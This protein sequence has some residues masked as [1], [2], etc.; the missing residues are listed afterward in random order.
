MTLTQIPSPTGGEKNIDSKTI[1]LD[2]E[3]ENPSINHDDRAQDGELLPGVAHMKAINESLT[4]R[5]RCCLIFS[6]FLVCYA[7]NLNN[8]TLGTYQGYA[9]SSWDQHSL[10]STINVIR[11]VIS[12]AVMPLTAKVS[13]LVGRVECF[14]IA[15]AFYVVGTVVQASAQNIET[16]AAG[17]LLFQIGFTCCQLLV[18]I[19]V[20]DVTSLRSR[21]LFLI[22]PNMPNIIN[23]WVSGDLTSAVLGHTS[24][25][26]GIGIW[27]IIYPLFTVPLVATIVLVGRRARLSHANSTSSETKPTASKASRLSD[28][29]MQLDL[30][31]L[32][33]LTATL[34]LVLIP[35]TSA[36]G[37]SQKWKTPGILTPIILGLLSLAAFIVWEKRAPRA[38]IPISLCKDRAVW[39]A[40]GIAVFTSVSWTLQGEFL[41]TVLLVGYDF[42]IKAATRVSVLYNFSETIAGVLLGLVIFKVRRCKPFIIAGVL[43]WFVAY[44]IM[45][46]FR[47]GS[48]SSSRAGIISGQVLLGAAGAMFPFPNIVIAMSV[49]QHK[50]I[51]ILTSL[52]LTMNWIGYAIGNCIAGA[53]WTQTLFERLQ[54]D[55]GPVNSTLVDA[56]YGAPLYVVP[57]YPIGTPERTAIVHSYRF[58]QQ[59]MAIAAV[60]FVVPILF[61]ALVIRNPKLKGQF[62]V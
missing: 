37:Q 48:D 12:A 19:I 40:M 22:L 10:L 46:H 52:W 16:F 4:F 43:V 7:L 25:R 56:V 51:A 36:G 57:S 45:I 28:L 49:T 50:D 27:S 24:W 5:E 8:L 59:L 29:A 31:G 20:S 55:L 38:L 35:L 18:E 53:I 34:A 41:Y 6:L 32:F 54:R 13:D 23:V 2:N 44:G 9:T 26:W 3:T 15:T 61:F 47:G 17:S 62:A 60:S 39:A 14:A 21:S 42:T 11:G 58:I 33:F 1:V 30:P